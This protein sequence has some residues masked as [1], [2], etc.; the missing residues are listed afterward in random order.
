MIRT[1]RRRFPILLA[2]IAALA[3]AGAVLASLFSTAEA[4]AEAETTNF[5][6]WR[7]TLTVGEDSGTLGYDDSDSLGSIS[8]D[9]DFGYPPWNPPHKHY[10]DR[11]SYYSVEAIK[12][13]EDSGNTVLEVNFS[14]AEKIAE[15]VKNGPGNVTLWLNHTAYP[16]S[17]SGALGNDLFFRTQFDDTPD[18]TWE[19]DDEVRV[20]LVYARALP[21]APTNVSV[22]AP[23]GEDG[24]LE[25][26]WNEAT[27]GTFEIECY[28]VEFR[29][30]S[31]EAL[32]KTS[33]NVHL[34]DQ[35]KCHLSNLPR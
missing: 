15:K 4:E 19:E 21:S 28:L 13:S 2:A 25:V 18:V 14:G 10:F 32:S 33:I 35:G 34:T 7:T 31:G 6:L 26:S 5:Y 1:D 22:T 17:V 11:E 8:T 9:A 30:P 24:T 20:A 12:S 3:V 29:H 16:V 23:P 27:K